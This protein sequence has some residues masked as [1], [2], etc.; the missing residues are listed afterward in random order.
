MYYPHHRE[1]A[2]LQVLAGL[3]PSSEVEGL[4]VV[5]WFKTPPNARHRAGKPVTTRADTACPLYVT[6]VSAHIPTLI[7][8]LRQAISSV[9]RGSDGRECQ[10]P[11]KVR[12]YKTKKNEADSHPWVGM[13]H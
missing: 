2:V 4:L 3:I 7:M 13:R 6:L 1:E 8:G 10:V 11:S 5:S 9:S 12:R